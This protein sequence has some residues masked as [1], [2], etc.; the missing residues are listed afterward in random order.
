MSKWFS[1]QPFKCQVSAAARVLFSL[2]CLTQDISLFGE[3]DVH[4][5]EHCPVHPLNNNYSS[6]QDAVDL[7]FI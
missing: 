3:K 7:W 5:M 2:K 4:S 6:S 1:L